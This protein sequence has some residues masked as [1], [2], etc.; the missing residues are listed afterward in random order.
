[1][2]ACTAFTGEYDAD[3]LLK[4]ADSALYRAKEQGRNCFEIFTPE[5]SMGSKKEPVAGSK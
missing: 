1:V 5:M 4:N 3:Q 2:G